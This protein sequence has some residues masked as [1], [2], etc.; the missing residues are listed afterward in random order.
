MHILFTRPLEDCHEMILKFQSLGHEISH[1]PLINIE[2]LKYEAPNYSEFKA[3]IFTSANAVKFLDIK[4]IDKKLKCFCVGSATE[5]KARSVGFQNVFAAEGNVSNLKE[6]ILQ[7]FKPS[8]GKLIYISGEII[9]SDLDK[10]LISSGY[11]IER[12]INYRANPIE[13]YDESFIEKLK[14]KMP[15]ITYIYSQN[16]AINFLKVIKSYQ[17]ETLWMNTNLMCIGEK[18]SSILNEIKWKKIFLFNPGEEEFLLYK[19]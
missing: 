14:L 19:I 16:S 6:L 9:S 5:K 13:K 4:N 8:D 18:T 2:G 17:L 15:E 3:I 10:E 12:L 11:T 1:L 7:N